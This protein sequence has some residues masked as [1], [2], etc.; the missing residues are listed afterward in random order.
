MYKG[1]YGWSLENT[2]KG[3]V[4]TKYHIE[5]IADEK[6]WK[7]FC[8]TEDI[9]LYTVRELDS[10]EKALEFFFGWFIDERCKDIKMWQE[11]YVNGEMV[12][13]Q[14]MIPESGLGF[15]MREHLNKEMNDRMHVS[16]R[17]AESLK[18]SNELCE[19]FISRIGADNM[20]KQFLKEQNAN[21]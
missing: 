13:E 12:L 20:Y 10:M 5:Y 21:E 3:T 16:E 9:N 2:N 18:K 8:E 15:L 19:K 11:V 6:T 17:K 7:K 1:F 14:P 4:E